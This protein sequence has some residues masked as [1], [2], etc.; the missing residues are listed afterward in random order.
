MIPGKKKPNEFC[1]KITRWREYRSQQVIFLNDL[2]I[3][4]SWKNTATVYVTKWITFFVEKSTVYVRMYVV[5]A[6]IDAKIA[7][8]SRP[9]MNSRQNS[10]RS[11]FLQIYT[12]RRLIKNR[13]VYR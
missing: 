13:F 8:F 2:K 9:S 4:F 12:F 7:F 3:V 10:R 1:L 5:A 6:W 11:E